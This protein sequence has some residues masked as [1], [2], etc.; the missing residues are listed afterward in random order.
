VTTEGVSVSGR[1]EE[2]NESELAW[3]ASLLAHLREDG[4]A[5]DAIAISFAFE[6]S[7]RSWFGLPEHDRPDPNAFIN[8][9]GAGL[10]DVLVKSLDLR[11]VVATAEHGTELALHGEPG[12]ILLYPMNAVGKRW[13]D[14]DR[15][16]LAQFVEEVSSHV[17]GVR[18]PAR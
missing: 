16:S 6:R 7:R 5:V 12:N 13:V 3:L 9:I 11:W 10:G 18:G 17:W 1:I 15:Q 14:D 8:S 2:V 4:I